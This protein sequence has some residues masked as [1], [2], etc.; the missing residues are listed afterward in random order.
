MLVSEKEVRYVAHLARLQLSDEEVKTL[1]NDM[2][3]ILDYMNLLN[4]MDTS[5]VKPLEHIIDFENYLREDVT[6]EPLPH[7][8]ALRNAPDTDTDYF[9]VPKVIE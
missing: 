2:S 9:R 6:K 3:Q 7:E 1:R 5:E 4:E 8:D